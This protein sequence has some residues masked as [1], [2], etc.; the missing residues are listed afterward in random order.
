MIP[1]VIQ[2]RAL[3]HQEIID[4]VRIELVYTLKQLCR[5]SVDE[6][7]KRRYQRFRKY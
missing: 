3:T 7:R 2:E 1:E 6:L 4:Q 5:L